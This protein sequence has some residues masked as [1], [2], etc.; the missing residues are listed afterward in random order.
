MPMHKYVVGKDEDGNDVAM[1]WGADLNWAHG[2]INGPEHQQ[3]EYYR[4][5]GKGDAHYA[6]VRD[7]AE[8]RDAKN[9]LIYHYWYVVMHVDGKT[10]N[11]PTEFMS[12][13]EGQEVCQIWESERA[14]TYGQSHVQSL[15]RTRA[16]IE[17]KSDDKT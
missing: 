7:L 6:V 9:H 13:Y 16:R 17:D 15:E 14:H 8:K 11:L 2:Y 10:T 5:K 4:A 1:V 3:K 12:A